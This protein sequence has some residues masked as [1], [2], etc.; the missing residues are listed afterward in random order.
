MKKKTRNKNTTSPISDPFAAREAAQYEN[1]IPSRE[2]ISE[3]LEKASGPLDFQRVAS[4][5]NI[6]GEEQLE[7]LRRRLRA[8]VRDGQLIM[9]RKNEFGLIDKMD[10]VKGRVQ[11]HR[12]GFGFLI[13]SD[14]GDDIYL[15]SR[16][17]Q[18]VFD[19][20][21]A[22][23]SPGRTDFK[24]RREGKIVQVLVHNT[25]QIVGRF[26][27]QGSSHFVRPDNPRL[28]HDI[29]IPPENTA[30]AQPGQF[31][32]VEITQ[33]PDRH[34]K[35]MG[36]I[37]EVLGDHMAPGMEIDVAIRSNGIPHTWPMDV[38]EQAKEF[39]S[40][41]K[42]ADKPSRIDLR[43]LPFV[44]IDGED[45][46]DFDDAVYCEAKRSGGWR[47]YVA[48][49]DVSHYVVPGS[50]LDQE[51]IVRGNSVYFPDFVVPM[52]PQVLS[53][54]LCSL[55][56]Q[57]D[58]L[59]MVCEM[60]ISAAGKIS[61]YT[62]FEGLMH[63]HA[64]LT[65]TQVGQMIADREKPQSVIRNE[66]EAILPHIDEL[67]S[68]YLQLRVT[69]EQRGAID[70]ETKET[71]ILFDSERK[72]D[73]I[74]PVERNEAHK[75]I[76]ECMLAAN[77]CAAKLLDSQ[78]VPAL[79]RVHESPSDEKLEM[80]LAFL[81]EMGLSMK[82]SGKVTPQDYRDVLAQ[83]QDRP[84]AHLIQTVMLRSMN[85]ARYQPD[86]RG[87]FG[88][89]YDAY[90]HFTSPIR[91]YPDL[92]V[93][94]AIRALIRSN[95]KTAKVKRIDATPKVEFATSYPYSSGDMVSFGEQCSTTERRAD[96]A[97][98]DVISWLKCE[99]LQEHVGEEFNG[100][101]SAVTPFGLFV[102]LNDIYIEGLV[103]ITA[104][105][106]DYYHHEAAH[107]RLVGERTHQV[108]R[109]SDELRVQVARVDL[110]ERKIDFEF[111]QAKTKRRSKAA[112]SAPGRKPNKKR[113][114]KSKAEESASV[115]AR[116]VRKRP[117]KNASADENAKPKKTTKNKSKTSN[118]AG[119]SKVKPNAKP[120]V[121]AKQK[122]KS[123]AKPKAK[124]KTKIK[125]GGADTSSPKK[126][127]A[128]K[129][130]PKA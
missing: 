93:H 24:G 16:Q 113:A 116:K 67:Y 120:K 66:Y 45:A 19:G 10:L 56:P 54:G 119:K 5:L 3:I 98:R 50:P 28:H 31:V 20:D 2:L 99:Y 82:G 121:N 110:D 104:L 73:K 115:P 109:I 86:N 123:K 65:Y 39:T 29:I 90:A 6:T 1:P 40:E 111:I 83:I 126:K 114:S 11:G 8:M 95:S 63:S 43:H 48:I 80:L 18:K 27:S 124:A 33:Q 107:H 37:A 61:G 84:E 72:I 130:K 75:L 71:R 26:V 4:A 44:T 94:R 38:Q 91:R 23:V 59:C 30:N 97:T 79:Y 13:P 102:E 55:N 22:L 128:R 112:V 7:A 46:R 17:M 57:V 76:E 15:T 14:G 127:K 68:L 92:L 77:V 9:N 21:E 81:G 53:N 60:T 69:R 103:H 52:L 117:V 47:L 64:R 89:S 96:D 74:V 108:F 35:P 125:V 12:D 51:A 78:E 100:V 118:V 88:L 122:T 106:K 85:Q 62:F 32:V 70:F 25:S 87:H 41:V 101:I 105:P 58:R 42:E 36:Q 129:P 49:A 34:K